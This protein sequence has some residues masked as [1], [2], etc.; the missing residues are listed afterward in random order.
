MATTF[1]SLSDI[2]NMD[3]TPPINRDLAALGR[4]KMEKEDSICSDYS[5]SDIED[6][7]EIESSD[8]NLDVDEIL[9]T[10]SLSSGLDFKNDKYT[11]G[12]PPNQI[13]RWSDSSG[14]SLQDSPVSTMVRS[15]RQSCVFH[16]PNKSPAILFPKIELTGSE[17]RINAN[18]TTEKTGITKMIDMFEDET[19]SSRNL[20]VSNETNFKR[21]HSEP[22]DEYHIDADQ[23]TLHV[24]RK[25]MPLKRERSVSQGDPSGASSSDKNN[26]NNEIPTFN[27]LS[28]KPTHR[29]AGNPT[30]AQWKLY[31]I[32][33]E[34][35][36]KSAE[37]NDPQK[38]RTSSDASENTDEGS[39]FKV[40]PASKTSSHVSLPR[41]SGV[42]SLSGSSIGTE[43]ISGVENKSEQSFG[44]I[45]PADQQ[46]PSSPMHNAL[47]YKTI[48]RR[49]RSKRQAS[50]TLVNPIIL[51]DIQ[52]NIYSD[53]EN[54]DT[55]TDI[56]SFLCFDSEESNSKKDFQPSS[57]QL[58]I[59]STDGDVM[60]RS[61]LGRTACKVESKTP[62]VIVWSG[63]KVLAEKKKLSLQAAK[64][65]VLTRLQK[66]SLKSGSVFSAFE[67]EQKEY[68]LRKNA[69]ITKRNKS[70]IH[71]PTQNYIYLDPASHNGCN[72]TSSFG[73]YHTVAS[74]ARLARMRKKSLADCQVSAST[75]RQFWQLEEIRNTSNDTKISRSKAWKEK[76]S[77]SVA[78][79]NQQTV[80]N[81]DHL[82]EDARMNKRLSVS[83]SDL[84]ICPENKSF[85]P[86][87]TSVN[88]N[89]NF[90]QL[91][92]QSPLRRGKDQANSIKRPDNLVIDL[93]NG[94]CNISKSS[95]N[96]RLSTRL[97]NNRNPPKL[98][99]PKNFNINISPVM[100]KKK[101]QKQLPGIEENSVLPNKQKEL[102]SSIE[103]DLNTF[104]QS[105]KHKDKLKLNKKKSYTFAS[106]PFEGALSEDMS[107]LDWNIE[108]YFSFLSGKKSKT[109]S[110][111]SENSV[112]LLSVNKS[113]QDFEVDKVEPL[114][115]NPIFENL[116]ESS[117]EKKTDTVKRRRRKNNESNN[118]PS[119]IPDYMK[120][121]YRNALQQSNARYQLNILDK[122]GPDENTFQSMETFIKRPSVQKCRRNSVV[123]QSRTWSGRVSERNKSKSKV[124]FGSLSIA[125]LLKANRLKLTIAPQN[126]NHVQSSN[127]PGHNSNLSLS[128]TNIK[129]GM[130]Q[131]ESKKDKKKKKGKK[132]KLTKA[133][134]SQP[135][136]F[137]H[138]GHVGWDPNKGFDMNEVDPALKD[139][140]THAGISETQLQ[141]KETAQFIYDFIEKR[142]GMDAIKQQTRTGPPPPPPSRGGGRG[143]APPPPPSRGGPPPPP[144]SRNQG[145]PPPP[146][147]GYNPP[148]HRS[149]L[150]PPPPS[151]RSRGAPPPPPM[152][153][154]PPP[155]SAPY[156]PMG[157]APPPPPPPPPAPMAPPPPP[158]PTGGGSDRS[159]LLSA[160]RGGTNLKA[161]SAA[162][163][164]E[165]ATGRGALLDQI[166]Q[167]KQLKTVSQDEMR[168]K[169]AEDE[170]DGGIAG[171]LA[172]ALMQR[173]KA[174]HDSDSESD[175]G[176]F[177]DDEDWD[178]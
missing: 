9:G 116:T 163:P 49:T 63:L 54:P 140:F 144:P 124:K 104:R 36:R 62:E 119:Y 79:N 53:D 133:D 111:C 45:C 115:Y 161:P 48:L 83:L 91:P 19:T 129:G 66:M 151:N 43:E 157:G 156:P 153:A 103:T 107:K 37:K 148:S 11:K 32:A 81:S 105:P 16:S 82:H 4:G 154:P 46:K 143:S 147:R 114:S 97:S 162:P 108:E 98:S 42:V 14:I 47:D 84:T 76:K 90:L 44:P 122:S 20:K 58:K 135:Q 25:H 71:H 68:N 86:N 3:L 18:T 80:M 40:I 164:P 10:K 59:D 141:D 134:I 29:I 175:D 89:N 55:V 118:I 51:Q 13:G 106:D 41:S 7:L 166:R 87:N 12:V 38:L 85:M 78:C 112:T 132:G 60:K 149:E 130:M 150:P 100:G 64:S 5:L 120:P 8:L 2:L 117:P 136:D 35:Y 56:D 27:T 69:I 75:N 67:N 39:G 142:G 168:D 99:M 21:H 173:E 74:P 110:P 127:Q 22:S 176:E 174:I 171:A 1:A 72:M 165:P 113:T 102:S 131:E 138:V 31:N 73:Q 24:T 28:N 15:P 125:R 57:P 26:N 95:A 169:P 155:M 177:N 121:A 23:K 6:G 126:Q 170:D 167:G 101:L 93:N 70:V 137:K 178:D 92:K 34:T 152:G 52:D 172:R 77:M 96:R 123:G 61:S 33:M 139:L 160:I 146:S 109:N 158:M 94:T 17:L 159:D 128:T 50:R 30:S 88:N 65:N 145:P